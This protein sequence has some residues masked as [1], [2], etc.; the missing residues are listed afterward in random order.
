LVRLEYDWQEGD[1]Y[2][3]LLAYLYPMNDTFIFGGG[4]WESNPPRT[5]L[6]PPTLFE[7]KKSEKMKEKQ[8]LYTDK[9]T[10]ISN[11]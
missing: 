5:I 3:R 2:R 8:L 9:N 4:T 7:V 10:L 6:T 1:S 11:I